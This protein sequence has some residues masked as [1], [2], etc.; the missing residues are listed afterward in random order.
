MPQV[1]PGRGH[2]ELVR[3]AT[4]HQEFLETVAVELLLRDP[5][6]SRMRRITDLHAVARHAAEVAVDTAATWTEH[7][8]GFYDV[9][10]V[11]RILSRGGTPVSKQAVS[12]RRGLLALTTGSGRVVYPQ[13]QFDGGGTL[14]GLEGVLRAVPEQLVS[15]WTLAS[16]LVSAQDE[17]G[18]D[19]PVTL[20]RDGAV[21]PVVAA[22]RS[23]ASALAA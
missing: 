5:D 12:K 23:W 3:G 10:G 19:T 18:G 2:P 6:G 9:E 7:L 15:R 16:W 1:P 21:Q 13:F 17:L 11:R 4:S 20:L 22:A 14:A 8:G